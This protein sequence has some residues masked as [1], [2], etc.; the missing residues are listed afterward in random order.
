MAGSPGAG[1][2]TIAKALFSASG[3]KIIDIDKFWQMF[4]AKQMQGDYSKFGQLGIRQ[5]EIY[6]GGRLGMLIDGTAKNLQVMEHI[7]TKLDEIGYESAM[8]FVNTDL[9]TSL[10][11]VAERGVA[12]GRTIDPQLV[13]DYWNKVQT[14]LGHLQNMFSG[15]FFIIDNTKQ[16]NIG[17]V[18]KQMHAWL[19]KPVTNHIARE[20]IKATSGNNMPISV[21]PVS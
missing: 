12:T 6:S 13:T 14:N 5:R 19:N 7:K 4:Q 18:A 15:N 17:P 11:R 16:L 9:Q 8:V 3:L 10:D 1:K 2:S 20:W 21:N